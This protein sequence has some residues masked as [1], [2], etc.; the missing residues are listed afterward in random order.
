MQLNRMDK[1]SLSV[2]IDEKLA[3]QPYL[4]QSETGKFLYPILHIILC[5]Y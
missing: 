1:Q 5:G 2:E 3:A 4:S